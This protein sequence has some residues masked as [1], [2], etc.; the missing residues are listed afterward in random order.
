[1]TTLRYH[2]NALAYYLW[3]LTHAAE[4]AERVVWA[5]GKR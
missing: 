1:M 5:E 2:L 3:L 4:L